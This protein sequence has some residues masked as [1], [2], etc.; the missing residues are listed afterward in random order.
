MGKTVFGHYILIGDIGGTNARLRLV[1]VSAQT[2]E[3]QQHEDKWITKIFPTKTYSSLDACI[4]EL[5]KK[6]PAIKGHM[7]LCSLG[8]AGPITKD[9]KGFDHT[10]MTNPGEKP[11]KIHQKELMDKYKFQAAL[12]LNDFIANGHALSSLPSKDYIVLNAGKKAPKRPIA[13]LGAG[14]G[15]GETY[16][17]WNGASYDVW[18]SEGGHT[19]YAPKDQLEFEFLQFQKL[20][21]KLD[22]ISVERVVSG[23]GLPVIYEFLKMKK[24]APESPEIAKALLAAEE[25][26]KGSVIS[27]YGLLTDPE[28]PLCKET[29]FFFLRNYFAEA[30]NLALK[31]LPYGGLFIVGGIAANVYPTIIKHKEELMKHYYNKGRMVKLLKDIPVYLVTNEGIGMHGAQVCAERELKKIIGKVPKSKL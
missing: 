14:T 26:K 13:C 17:T 16:L 29:M 9:S 19:D 12:I 4:D 30:G 18:D 3:V 6:H 8:V 27:K 31:T 10:L 24:I 11:W 2:G 28:D 20:F 1:P 23:T 22:R 15:L 7:I 25:G 5:I 21:L